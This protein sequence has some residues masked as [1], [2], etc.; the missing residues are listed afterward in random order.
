MTR[1]IRRYLK[2]AGICLGSFFAFLIIVTIAI[3]VLFK[4]QLIRYVIDQLNK[5]VD[6]R[7]AIG[8]IDF[9]LWKQFPNA[10]VQLN[11]VYVQSSN[12]Y[13]IATGL[14]Q[15]DT[16]LLAN[17]IF[18]EFNLFQLLSGHYQLKR[19]NIKDGYVNLKT[20][21]QGNENFQ[22]IKSSEKKATPSSEQSFSLQLKDV[23]FTNTWFSYNNLKS[24]VSIISTADWLRLKGDFRSKLF[25]IE[26]ATSMFAH[27]L[28][29]N[30]IN[31]LFDR[32]V[33]IKFNLN[34]NDSLYSFNDIDLKLLHLK[35][36]AHGK[37]MMTKKININFQVEGHKL[38][39]SQI[40]EILPGAVKKPLDEY[41]GKGAVS[42]KV[43][44]NGDMD[45]HT[46]PQIHAD[47][48]LDDGILAQ[49]KTGVKLKNIRLTGTYSST[50][51]ERKQITHLKLN[52]FVST[53]ESGNISG[54]FSLDDILEPIVK[55]NIDYNL[56][57]NEL[58]KFIKVDTIE[59][60]SG[61]VRGNMNVSATLPALS[62][63]KL[64]DIRNVT[65]DGI[66]KLEDAGIKMKNSDYHFK[67]INGSVVLR[68]D[69][70]FQNISLIVHDNDFLINGSLANGIQYLLKQ[71]SDVT[72]QADVKSQHLDLSKYF[73]KD[74]R[75]AGTE[76]SRELL[77]PD[78]INL[79]VKIYIDEFKLN[80]FNAKRVSG[81]VNYKP[82]I[83]VLK[84]LSFESLTGK[85]S[86]NGV[87]LQDMYKNFI[88]KGQVDVNRLNIQQMFYTFDNF[89]QTVLLDR[90]LRGRVSG[91]IGLSAEWNNS[92]TLNKDK[93]QVDADLSIENGELV[94]FEPIMSLSKFISV[95]E[96]RNIKFSN[97]QNK[98]II[99]D[100]QIIIPQMDI[101]SS[102]FHI[103]AS[104]IHMFD[105]HYTY[106]VK[107]LLS[108]V[109]WGKA[110]KAKQQNDEFGV[111]EDD[112]L[113]RTGIYLSV[114]G[115]NN[116]YKISYDS[117]QTVA[118]MKESL[119]K[120]K[121]ELKTIL[122]EEFGFYKND[123]TLK[124][125]KTAGKSNF[126]VKWDDDDAGTKPK[127]SQ[128]A[129]KKV[130]KPKNKP[131]EEK[132]KIEWE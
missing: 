3:N 97:L 11:N 122:K 110:R 95:D 105:N 59:V 71:R 120:Q 131:S 130:V 69:I 48:S 4:D 113:G 15:R 107:V 103:S 24:S 82:K 6:V 126:R 63:I 92:F 47:F 31:Y 79:D 5:Q 108:E 39:L 12:H 91:K 20:D 10:S 35:F 100:K 128:P 83:F 60:L 96:L 23:L 28:R 104:G 58:Q 45:Q 44:I 7:I 26:V 98:I 55:A 21:K 112:G 51:G 43:S 89:S 13:K 1:I 37:L 30:D 9:S 50:P 109:L 129:E 54:S 86:G 38:D 41:T 2:I 70:L 119:K 123:S 114:T 62:A 22:I 90:H 14:K 29:V 33:I 106:K 87:V 80:K 99:K 72:L 36:L 57:L 88:V 68:N 8:K 65:C 73:V 25:D 76:Y 125:N 85:V 81:Y 93:L 121:T 34:V 132:A 117:K 101:A 84:S 124:T 56:N 127:E 94:N 66:L 118:Q 42:M 17:R 16:L 61:W 32:P 75:K 40:L 52:K 78:N 49:K 67:K 19:L 115:F 27:E 18:L 53:L 102:A 77:F 116:E 74:S 64:Q 111:I 46:T